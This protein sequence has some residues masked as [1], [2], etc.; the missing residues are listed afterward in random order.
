[1]SFK[2][3]V[4]CIRYSHT[5]PRDMERKLVL[6]AEEGLGWDEE[7]WTGARGGS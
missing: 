1:M 4:I 7:Q 5:R 2:P 6:T 3:S